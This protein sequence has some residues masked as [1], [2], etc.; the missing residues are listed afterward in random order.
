[1]AIDDEDDDRVAKRMDDDAHADQQEA[2]AQVGTAHTDANDAAAQRSAQQ[3]ARPRRRLQREQ[4]SGQRQ[5]QLS[6]DDLER[7]MFSLRTQQRP[8]LGI[9]AASIAGIAGAGVWAAITVVTGYQVGWIAIGVGFL[10][11]IVMR[12]VGRGIEQKFA[13]LGGLIAGI[14]VALGNLFSVFGFIAQEEGISFMTVLLNF[15]YSM[16]LEVLS[17]M[18]SPTDLLFY[19]IAVYA[20]YKFSIRQVDDEELVHLAQLD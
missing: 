10:V 18:F 20:G 8:L 1:M 17:L 15:D 4:E 9:L 7:A 2:D 16:T 6:R 11:G 19:A 5:E 12:Y 13:V 3:S 14:S